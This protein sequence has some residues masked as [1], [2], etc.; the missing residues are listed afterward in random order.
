MHDKELPKVSQTNI[1]ELGVSI[2]KSIV[3]EKISQNGLGCLFRELKT[4]DFGIDG[5]IEIVENG[6]VTGKIISVQIKSGNSYLKNNYSESWSVYIPKKTVNYWNSHSVPVLLILVDTDL[7]KCY[8]IRADLETHDEK[9]SSYKIKVL[10]KQVLD[11]SSYKK[12]KFIAEN[13]TEAGRKLAKL[14]ADFSL[15]KS[16]SRGSKIVVDI[17]HWWNKMSGRS[18][19][20]IGYGLDD[21]YK[22][23]PRGMEPIT[24]FTTLGGSGTIDFVERLFPWSKVNVDIEFIES[25]EDELY[26]EYL[27]ETGTYDKEMD[28][29]IDIRDNFSEWFSAK[30]DPEHLEPYTLFS[31]EVCFYRFKL[32]LNELGISYLKVHQYLNN[33]EEEKEG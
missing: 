23:N 9:K 29:Y 8:W 25:I 31:G 30:I 19:I 10:K 12:I 7:K 6:Q 27:Q 4:A 32:E 16:I 22:G 2:V 20:V 24:S 11:S 33:Q 26:D 14:E 21:P 5:Q 17:G 28:K 18:D 13:T 15:I 3:N 1:S